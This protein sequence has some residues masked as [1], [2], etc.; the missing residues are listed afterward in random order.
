MEL[1]TENR[2]D[3]KMPLLEMPAES[4][5]ILLAAFPDKTMVRVALAHALWRAMS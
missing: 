1:Q 5:W 4:D 3:L 2:E